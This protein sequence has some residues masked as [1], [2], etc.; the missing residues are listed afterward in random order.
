MRDI[1]SLEYEKLEKLL[2]GIEKPGRYIDNEIGTSSKDPGKLKPDSVIVALAF[3]DIYEVGMPNIGLQILYDIINRHPSFSAER[4]FAPWTDME[5]QLRETGTRLFSL[6]NRIFMESFDLIGFSLQHELL[7]SNTLNMLDLGGIRL[8]SEERSV[9]TPLICAGGPATVNPAPM[10]RFMD[11]MVIG[12]GEEVI[13]PVLENLARFRT[14]T[15]D[16]DSFLR[17]IST[18][19][20]I[21]VPAYHK[22]IYS[23]GGKLEK[24]EPGNKTKKAVLSD[25][26][27]IHIVTR[28]IIPNIKPV[29]DRFAVEIMRGCGRGCRFCQAGFTNRP[30]RSRSADRL[31]EQSIEGLENT[32]Y[33][34]I[35]FLSLST[36]DYRDLE[37]LI[38]GVS[39]KTEEERLSISLPS[40]RLDSFTMGIAELVQQG[41]KT[42]LTFA[43]EAGSQR[44]RDIINKNI[45][46]NDILDCIELAFRKGW[47]KIKLYFM[48]GFPGETGEDVLEI[49]ALIKK[50]ATR[51]RNVM[52]RDKVKRFNMNVSINVFNPKP[53][54]P[55]Q[56]SSQEGVGSLKKKFK[57]ILDNVHQRYIKI[58]WSDPEK[59]RLECTLSRGD[60]R[61]G[62]VIEDAW[63]NGAKFDNWADL[64]DAS[65][66]IDS[67]HKNDI[68]I[69]YYTDREYNTDEI[70]P[71]DV[72]DIGVNKESLL[73][74]YRRVRKVIKD[75]A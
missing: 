2:R 58:S 47:E 73:S 53:F 61:I 28:P 66:W 13:I 40:M 26:D 31:I 29:H 27:D 75:K 4:F 9:D 50:V 21:Y 18:M 67:F 63:K 6:E 74:V 52:P 41:R 5:Q 23:D 14:G 57:L 64:F 11:F 35:S 44:M 54:T 15:I 56:W 19:D 72:V 25:L 16:K 38:R 36:S 71:W 45:T 46:E 39:E 17:Q 30:V 8:V 34:E 24:I 3:P 22:Y 1:K 69:G 32:G 10:S 20:G 65:P 12:D 55:F 48:I 62:K 37:R 7:F 33:D 49:A 43:P 68:K 42:G 60:T 70:L 59:S 51:A